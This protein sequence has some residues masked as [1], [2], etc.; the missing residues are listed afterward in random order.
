MFVNP[1]EVFLFVCFHDVLGF[2]TIMTV[3]IVA[4][5]VGILITAGLWVVQLRDPSLL[6]EL[7]VLRFV[8][9]ASPFAVVISLGHLVFPDIVQRSAEEM[10]PMSGYIMQARTERRRKVTVLALA[11]GAANLL[12]MLFTSHALSR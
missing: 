5:T 7:P 1:N 8:A 3:R 9:L 2:F 12:F 11:I 4:I 10:G 6:Y